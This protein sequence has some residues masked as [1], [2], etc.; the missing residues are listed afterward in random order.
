MDSS[1][2]YVFWPGHQPYSLYNSKVQH[3]IPDN[4]EIFPE[5]IMVGNWNSS[6]NIKDEYTGPY[7]VPPTDKGL[8]CPNIEMSMPYY[9]RD[10]RELWYYNINV[11]TKCLGII[12]SGIQFFFTISYI[13]LET[14][15]TML[16]SKDEEYQVCNRG[17][18]DTPPYN[19]V[20]M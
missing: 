18:K 12:Y 9:Y 3:I 15:L 13:I 10:F 8:L 7:H 11:R 2:F 14:V 4:C 5:L 20:T 16:S 19:I 6:S 17:K 1:Q